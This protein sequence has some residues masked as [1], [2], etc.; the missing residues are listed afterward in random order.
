[1]LDE[2]NDYASGIN[3]ESNIIVEPDKIV[4][5]VK[6]V[7]NIGLPNPKDPKVITD[8]DNAKNSKEEVKLVRSG[9]NLN[10]LFSR[11]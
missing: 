9:N 10:E 8:D 2:F 3:T 4:T 5:I 6:Q 7:N 11:Y 1:M